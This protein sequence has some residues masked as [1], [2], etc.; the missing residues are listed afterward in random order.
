MSLINLLRKLAWRLLG[1]DYQHMLYLVDKVYFKEDKYSRKGIKSYDHN[2]VVWRWSDGPVTVGKYTQI[3]DGV[4]FI[5]DNGEHLIGCVT[6]YPFLTTD[7]TKSHANKKG[8]KV[9][10]D[11]WIGQSSII[12]PGVTIGDGA[13]VGAGSVVTKDVPPYCVIAGVP[14]KVISEKCSEEEKIKMIELAWWDWPKEKIKAVSQ[15]FAMSIPEF[16]DKYYN[17]RGI[18][19]STGI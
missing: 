17:G 13:T 11:V 10:N 18:D 19:N 15:D 2:A 8:I 14:A 12:L 7:L 1:V 16:L 9:G 6:S 3:A 4:R 5:A